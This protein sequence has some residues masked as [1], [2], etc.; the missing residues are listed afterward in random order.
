MAITSDRIYSAAE[1][2]LESTFRPRVPYTPRE[3]QLPD[4][5]IRYASTGDMR[6]RATK[7]RRVSDNEVQIYV[8]ADISPYAVYTNEPWVSH[9]WKGKTNP[10]EKWFDRAV[11]Q[12]ATVLAAKL[13]GDLKRGAN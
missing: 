13:G 5:R 3:K 11:E 6:Y 12:F 7:I 2:V 1:S 9:Y 10:N 4:G 8:D